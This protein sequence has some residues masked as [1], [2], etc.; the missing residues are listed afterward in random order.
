MSAAATAKTKVRHTSAA[1]KLALPIDSS[2]NA[3]YGQENNDICM[4]IIKDYQLA[5]PRI[6]SSIANMHNVKIAT[7]KVYSTFNG[8]K[9]DVYSRRVSV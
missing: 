6:Q 3:D 1:P 9:L 5:L 8:N 7:T 2:I 4:E